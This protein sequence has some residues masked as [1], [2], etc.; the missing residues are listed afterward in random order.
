MLRYSGL[1]GCILSA[2][3]A[4]GAGGVASRVFISGRHDDNIDAHALAADLLCADH[5][6]GICAH[7]G[8]YSRNADHSKPAVSCSNQKHNPGCQQTR[9]GQRE[10]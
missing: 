2:R 4:A 8:T 9:C 7:H 10:T 1:P 6:F 3:F 5:H